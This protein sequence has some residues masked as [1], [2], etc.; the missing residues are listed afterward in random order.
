LYNDLTE[1]DV[2]V[3]RYAVELPLRSSKRYPL[4]DHGSDLPIHHLMPGLLNAAEKRATS[5]FVDELRQAVQEVLDGNDS[6]RTRQWLVL[7]ANGET[8]WAGDR[9]GEACQKVLATL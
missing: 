9:R 8:F 6:W 3:L 5:C 1:W 7:D 4:V 2:P